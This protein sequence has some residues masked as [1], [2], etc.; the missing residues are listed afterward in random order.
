MP[1]ITSKD[2]KDK[3]ELYQVEAAALKRSG[4]ALLT[5]GKQLESEETKAAAAVC[6]AAV[7][8]YGPKKGDDDE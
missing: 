7:L 3:I 5:I 2:G 6:F 8:E 1:K 4:N